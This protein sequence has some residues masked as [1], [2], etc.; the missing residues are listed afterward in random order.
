MDTGTPLTWTFT[1]IG[2]LLLRSWICW[3]Q[4]V[5]LCPCTRHLSIPASRRLEVTHPSQMPLL[6]ALMAHVL[7]ETT[8]GCH[9]VRSPITEAFQ[10][11]LYIVG[12]VFL[13]AETVHASFGVYP[14]IVASGLG[15]YPA[16]SGRSTLLSPDSGKSP[17]PCPRLVLV[18]RATSSD[19]PRFWAHTP[20]DPSRTPTRNP[21]NHRGQQ[22]SAIQQGK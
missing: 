11:A 12:G 14:G 13:I 1:M 8:F 15:H 3:G 22:S 18:L 16:R 9:M 10:D 19:G 2:L 4:L 21:Q 6:V 7:W 5:C 20:G 17:V